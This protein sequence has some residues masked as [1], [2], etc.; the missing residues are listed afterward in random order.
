MPGVEIF[1]RPRA[2]QKARHMPS[3]RRAQGW[4]QL[5]EEDGFSVHTPGEWKRSHR[6]FKECQCFGFSKSLNDCNNYF[7][8]VRH[9][10]RSTPVLDQ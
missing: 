8:A 1:C 3:K 10:R 4:E 9:L 6:F 7:F 5:G 2:A